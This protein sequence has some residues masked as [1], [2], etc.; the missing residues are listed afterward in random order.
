MAHFFQIFFDAGEI[1]RFL[2]VVIDMFYREHG[3]PHF[4]AV[5]GE[6]EASIE[7]EGDAAHGELPP[8]VLRLVLEWRALYRTELLRIGNWPGRAFRGKGGA[9]VADLPELPSRI[10][11]AN[12][13]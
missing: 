6:H 7:I 1:S 8:R 5:Y 12:S 11:V 13:R 9:P 3:A 4:H 10:F 2:G